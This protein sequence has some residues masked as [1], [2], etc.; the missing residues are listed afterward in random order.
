MMIQIG[1]QFFRKD[2]I[3]GFTADYIPHTSLGPRS[4]DFCWLYLTGKETPVKIEVDFGG[5]CTEW[6]KKLL[7][8]ISEKD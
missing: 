8:R 7:E 4:G 3:Q 1:K 2:Q 5:N 6:K